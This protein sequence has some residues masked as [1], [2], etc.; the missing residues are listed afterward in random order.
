MLRGEAVWNFT[1]MFLAAWDLHREK[2]E[3]IELFPAHAR[4]EDVITDGVVQPYD[5][6]PLD[7]KPVGA[8]VYHN[9]ISKAE[10]YIYLTTPLSHH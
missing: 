5:D 9:M 6:S 8:S 10:R 2:Q 7:D 3:N 1:V 4:P